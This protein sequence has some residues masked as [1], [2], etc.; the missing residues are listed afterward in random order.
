MYASVK[1]ALCAYVSLRLFFSKFFDYD[2][3]WTKSPLHFFLPAPPPMLTLG[4]G[5]H[6]TH[7]LLISGSSTYMVVNGAHDVNRLGEGRL[8]ATQD[9]AVHSPAVPSR[10]PFLDAVLS[11][12][13][14]L[15]SILLGFIAPDLIPRTRRLPTRKE[16]ADK[17][18]AASNR[19]NSVCPV[20][21]ASSSEE[22]LTPELSNGNSHRSVIY[23]L[24]IGY[25]P[26][27][28]PND[29]DFPVFI[30]DIFLDM[31]LSE[32]LFATEING[33][34][35]KAESSAVSDFL[36]F[37]DIAIA[38]PVID[39][40][41]VTRKESGDTPPSE[42]TG[43]YLGDTRMSS[44]THGL[45]ADL[46]TCDGKDLLPSDE[47]GKTINV[48]GAA[49]PKSRS[50]KIERQT[51]S[52]SLIRTKASQDLLASLPPIGDTPEKIPCDSLL[53][54]VPGAH[55]LDKTPYTDDGYSESG[56]DAADNC[57]R[58]ETGRKTQELK[59]EL[60]SPSGPMVHPLP[61][62]LPR[63]NNRVMLS[64]PPEKRCVL[65]PLYVYSAEAVQEMKQT[66]TQRAHEAGIVVSSNSMPGTFIGEEEA[67]KAKKFWDDPLAALPS[68]T[69]TRSP[70]I[71]SSPTLTVVSLG[72]SL[73]SI[74][75][76]EVASIPALDPQLGC[77]VAGSS[78][79]GASKRRRTTSTNIDIQ[80]GHENIPG[81]QEMFSPKRTKV[82]SEPESWR[83]KPAGWRLN[84]IFRV[85]FD[86]LVE[87]S[88]DGYCHESG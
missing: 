83:L 1:F 4:P 40:G 7:P 20:V 50:F 79:S 14:I 88:R 9:L 27:S 73:G 70:V 5:R 10:P 26:C 78:T 22:T 32:T 36:A 11:C 19:T 61:A 46:S 13:W 31:D 69:Q 49:T 72:S 28:T 77:E 16:S 6:F 60:A 30:D 23:D 29:A 62:P 18:K 41:F 25:A 42:S 87:G 71:P 12:G 55:E 37:E 51:G 17:A 52:S 67:Q 24:D 80:D 59:A 74:L 76:L 82:V 66:F 15:L 35:G 63:K 75:D 85:G 21:S 33:D 68:F 65:Q 84:L 44:F 48:S 53:H 56:S 81:H 2:A 8:N 58:F 43:L 3:S 57:L 39:T 45:V 54:L 38:S 86:D 64:I 47:S 34:L